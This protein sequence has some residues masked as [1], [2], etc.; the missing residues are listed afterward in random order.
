MEFSKI[1][2]TLTLNCC[3]PQ[4]ATISAIALLHKTAAVKDKY[5]L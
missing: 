2:R 5:M 4:G 1:I 3:T